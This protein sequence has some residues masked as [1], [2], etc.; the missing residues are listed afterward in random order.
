MDKIKSCPRSSF[1][2]IY[3][4]IGKSIFTHSLL[5]HSNFK[6]CKR[7]KIIIDVKAVDQGTL[8]LFKA[9]STLKNTSNGSAA[10]G[11]VKVW[12][13]RGVVTPSERV[14]VLP[15]QAAVSACDDNRAACLSQLLESHKKHR[16]KMAS[17][18]KKLQNK[19]RKTEDQWLCDN[20]N[21][22]LYT[23]SHT[24]FTNSTIIHLSLIHF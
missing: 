5:F 22:Y 11:E 19:G 7:L 14:L 12:F 17:L 9:H 1:S 13:L 2:W 20:W 24:V 15:P 6:Y 4:T 10:C 8:L 16:H 21:P 3:I 23:N 18:L